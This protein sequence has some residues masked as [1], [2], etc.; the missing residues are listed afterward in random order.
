MNPEGHI[1]ALKESAEEIE[2]AIRKG[3]KLRQRTIGFHTSMAACDM[4][5]LLL[6]KMNLINP[7]F[8]VKHDWFDSAKEIQRRFVSISF[9][10]KEEILALM[11]KIELKRN[12]LCYGKPKDIETIKEVIENFNKL[13]EKFIEA[14]LEELK[15]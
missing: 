7:G 10:K 3:I 8:V 11:N 4:L 14:G 15:E 9:P 13:K 12:L 1:A 6:H 2:E 5:E